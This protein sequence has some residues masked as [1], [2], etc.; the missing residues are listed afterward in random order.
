MKLEKKSKVT[1]Y[2]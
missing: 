1:I 2:F